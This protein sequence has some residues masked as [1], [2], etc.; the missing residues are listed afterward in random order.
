MI[1]GGGEES[2]GFLKGVWRSTD[3]GATWMLMSACPR[4]GRFVDTSV[5]LPDGKIIV[6]GY[7][8]NNLSEPDYF[9]EVWEYVDEGPTWT[10]DTAQ[11]R[12]I[13]PKFGSIRCTLP[14]GSIVSMGSYNINFGPV[15]L[16]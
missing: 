8:I 12:A 14:D 9:F 3:D 16:E 2:N 15:D 11:D 6:F 13:K 1:I 4:G 5:V 7:N 10:L